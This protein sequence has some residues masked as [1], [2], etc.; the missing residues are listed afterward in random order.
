MAVFKETIELEDKVSVPA[1]AA[2]AA[3][4]GLGKGLD[5][6]NATLVKTGNAVKPAG[7]A[8]TDLASKTFN[9]ANAIAVGKETIS[10]AIGGMKAAFSS[11]AAGDVKGAIQGVTDSIAGMAKL[12]DLVV[13]G[14]GQ[15]VSVVIQIAGGFV[16]ITAGLVKSMA[17]FAIAS[18]EAK[19]AS[20]ATWDALGGGVV[21][22]AEID[23]M[24][25]GLK[26]KLGVSKDQLGEFATGFLKMGINGKEALESLTT[27]AASA[28]AVTKGAGQGFTALFQ[29]VDAAA[30]T[31]A[32]KILLPAKGL[33]KALVAA[34]LNVQDM[35]KE[36]GLSTEEFSAQMAKGGIDAN[37]FGDAMQTAITKKG[38]GSLERLANSSA[39]IKKMFEENIGDM[40]EDLGDIVAPFMKEV[41]DLFS[42][43]QKDAPSAKAATAGIREVL[44][45]VFAVAT[46]LVPVVKHFLLDMVIY[47]LKAYIALKPIVQTI[48]DFA[49]SA[50]GVAVVDS[51][52][53]AL[54][55]IVGVVIVAIGLLAF[56]G[57]AL[58][59][60]SAAF[61][62]ALG[63]VL[64]FGSDAGT[65]LAEWVSGAATAASDFVAGLVSGITAGASQVIGAVKGLADGALGAFTG[66]LGIKSPSKVMMQMGGY[67][68]DGV[69]EGLDAGASDVHG[70]A[71]G[72]ADAAVKGTASGGS[73]GAPGGGKGGANITVNV[74]IDGAGK[75]A[76]AITQEMV[77]TVFQ[78][79]ALQA[80]V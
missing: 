65:A 10:A 19:A 80:G 24:L 38:I 32:G 52:V 77:S 4:S 48:R 46:S 74:Q 78:Q 61:G 45:K 41:A 50:A 79:M 8:M 18:S 67:M 12:L 75:S 42:I 69:A 59:V 43:F 57:A 76:F 29:K 58:V 68:T 17:E 23:E 14:L 30:Q 64:Q 7:A 22:G 11:L 5:S 62:A 21:A 47:S 1:K 6:A 72:V 70:A 34:G 33:Q 60:M 55:A 31:S 3:V 56:L 28:E 20:L 66:A 40:F 44:T 16:G 25:D 26:V 63:A 9:A 39:N 53:F 71:S 27:A 49:T 51:L 15:A 37:K 36:M 35:S 2:A 54:K 73:A 13:P